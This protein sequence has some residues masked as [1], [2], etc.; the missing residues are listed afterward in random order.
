MSVNFYQTKSVTTKEVGVTW[1]GVQWEENASP[2]L[3]FVRK[4]RFLD[5]ELKRGK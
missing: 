5:S 4:K 1:G 3:L 2:P